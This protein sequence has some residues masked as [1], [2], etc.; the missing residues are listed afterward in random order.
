[1]K[2]KCSLWRQSELVRENKIE[3]KSTAMA[4]S[5]SMTFRPQTVTGLSR[6]N[7]SLAMTASEKHVYCMGGP[8]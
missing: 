8:Y 3:L 4:S 2:G 6:Q 5:Q 7:Y 1:M